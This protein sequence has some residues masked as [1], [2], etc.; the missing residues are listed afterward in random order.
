M[1]RSSVRYLSLILGLAVASTPLAASAAPPMAEATDAATRID[2]YLRGRVPHLRMPGFALVVVVGDQV[3]L[4]RGYGVADRAAGTPMTEDTPVAIASTSKGMTAL[5]VMQ[6]VEQGLVDLDAPVIRYV[7]DFT[8]NDPR[9]VDVT[10]R[11]VLTHTAGLPAGGLHDPAQDDE[12]LERHIDSL[13]STELRFAPGGGYEYAN[14]GYSVAGLV[15][16][17]VSGVPYEDYLAAQVFEPLSMARTTFDVSRVSGDSPVT[18]RA[19]AR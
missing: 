14:D 3:I 7:P 4:S 15:V 16:Q 19:A 12:A 13:V 11:Q 9:A 8:L 5:A 2:T 6:L 18:A 17:R 1:Y 10:V